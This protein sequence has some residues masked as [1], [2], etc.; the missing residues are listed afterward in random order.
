MYLNFREL[1]SKDKA[2]DFQ[3]SINLSRIIEGRQDITYISPVKVDL[4]ARPLMDGVID[5]QGELTAELKMQCSRCLTPVTKNYV[6]PFHER[7]KL[8]ES[9]EE[10]DEDEDIQ[11]VTEEKINLESYVEE[12]MYMSLPY[13]PLCNEDCKG[14]CPTCGT[15]RNEQ[16]CGCSNEKIDPRLAALKDFFKQE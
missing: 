4:V 5:V 9:P 1:M 2:V 3:Q 10:M 8:A 13:A 16:S 12:E 7:F 6:I 14:L 11:L 15:N